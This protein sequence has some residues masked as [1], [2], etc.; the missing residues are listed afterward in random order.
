MLHTHIR[1][2][3]ST[4]ERLTEI[5]KVLRPGSDRPGT[6][7]T[8]DAIIIEALDVIEGKTTTS[9]TVEKLKEQLNPAAP[10]SIPTPAELHEGLAQASARINKLEA[11]LPDQIEEAVSKSKPSGARHAAKKKKV[12]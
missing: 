8:V 4:V 9:P 2:Q 3:K 12:S 1:L 5:L 11:K 10:S 6:S 7:T